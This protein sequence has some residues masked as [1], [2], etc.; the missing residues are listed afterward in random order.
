[1][2]RIAAA[3]LIAVSILSTAFAQSLSPDQRK[4]SIA[5]VLSLQ[6]A[7]QGFRA[8]GAAGPSSLGATNSCLRALKY[9]GAPVGDRAG[10]FLAA[11]R[12]DSGAFAEAPGATP[13]VRSTAMGLMSAVEMGSPIK[14]DADGA[15][16]AY[17]AK[18]AA[19]LPDLY[20]AAAAL[21]AAGLKTEKAAAWTAAFQA[22]RNPD[23]TYGKN[24]GDHTSAVVS[25]LR[26]GARLPDRA[27]AVKAL[28]AAQQANG[29]FAVMGSQ[30]DLSSSYRIMR[31]LW[32]LKEKPDL[33]QLRAFISRCRNADGGYG[34]QPG[35]PS[36]ASPTYFAAILLHWAEDLSK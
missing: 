15:I 11:C 2:R 23:G 4:A 26:L 29:G 19:S 22:S 32:M 12:Q 31:A 24:P 18:N 33:A 34:M 28:R 3:A 35:Q 21:D 8:G 30:G 5:Y 27:A 7:D 36:A 25:L 13:D 6:N 10:R 1:M 17:F 20:I 16:R 14:N 9:F